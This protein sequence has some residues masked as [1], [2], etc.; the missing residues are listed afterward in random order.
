MARLTAGSSVPGNG[1]GSAT[2]RRELVDELRA[3]SD[4]PQMVA[5]ASPIAA[6]RPPGSSRQPRVIR[7][8]QPSQSSV[9]EELPAEDVEETGYAEEAELQ[10]EA[11]EESAA[12]DE[13]YAAE[14][15]GDLAA[16]V[17]TATELA[18]H[19]VPAP[20]HADLIEAICFLEQRTLPE[21]IEAVVHQYIATRAADEDVAAV[22]TARQRY[23]KV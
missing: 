16:A 10:D 13:D 8:P 2:P 19:W 11:M 14:D 1:N 23:R 6:V 22:M 21:I 4:E 20:E 3:I 17:S 12:E 9:A 7:M 15:S 18:S 5:P